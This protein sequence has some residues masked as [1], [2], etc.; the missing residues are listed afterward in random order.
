MEYIY[1]ITLNFQDNYYDFYEWLPQDKI[2]NIKKIPIYKIKT[3]DYL[4]IKNNEIS[5]N[6]PNNMLLLT[7][8]IE[9]MGLLLNK[10]NKVIKKSS[11]TFEDTDDI[12]I[13]KD[14]IKPLTIKYSILKKKK[15]SHLSRLTQEK[16][17]YVKKFFKEEKDQYFLKY[18]YYDIFNIEEENITVINNN[19][20]KLLIT[21]IDK[22]Y[23]SI[24]NVNQELKKTN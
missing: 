16:E 23:Q 3:K 18:L 2:V 8:G 6:S 22:L 15:I 24:I 20:K 10:K 21:D 12:L 13:D 17:L 1:D 5:I 4:N 7:N 11:L 19:L 9:I 14:E